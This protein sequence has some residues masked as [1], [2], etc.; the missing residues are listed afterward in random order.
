MIEC[1]MVEVGWKI[2]GDQELVWAAIRRQAGVVRM[3][4]MMRKSGGDGVWHREKKANTHDRGQ[5]GRG[6]ACHRPGS[7]TCTSDRC[8]EGAD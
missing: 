2:I 8:A 7:C 3:R 4:M 6:N 5:L 1:E